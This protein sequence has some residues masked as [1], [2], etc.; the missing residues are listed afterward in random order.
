LANYEEKMQISDFAYEFFCCRYM[1][2]SLVDGKS[3]NFY[4]QCF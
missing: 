3:K 1:Q 2:V 4:L